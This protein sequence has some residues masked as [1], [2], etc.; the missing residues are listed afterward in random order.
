MGGKG[1]LTDFLWKRL[2]LLSKPCFQP[3]NSWSKGFFDIARH[4]SQT[5]RLSPFFWMQYQRSFSRRSGQ[6]RQEEC[7][8]WARIINSHLRYLPLQFRMY[9]SI[10]PSRTSGVRLSTPFELSLSKSLITAGNFPWK[11]SFA[12]TLDMSSTVLAFRFK[13]GFAKYF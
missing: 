1:S 8:Q 9:F 11:T 12:K 6:K 5:V 13:L 2:S 7:N 3:W 10:S 4:P